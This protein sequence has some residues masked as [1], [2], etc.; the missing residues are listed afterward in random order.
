MQANSTIGYKLSTGPADSLTVPDLAKK[1]QKE[2]ESALASMGLNVSVDNTRYSDS[3][4]EGR[5]ITTNPGAGS[6]VH[7]GDTVTLYISQGK[8]TQ[9]I[10]VP[11]VT[12]KYKDDAVTMLTNYGLYVYVTSQPSNTVERGL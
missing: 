8:D 11:D 7:A 10:T 3:I 9:S 12:G 1:T 6:A 5:V 2:A 4:A